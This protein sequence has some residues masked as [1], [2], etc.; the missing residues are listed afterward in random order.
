M[1]NKDDE[2]V[3]RTGTNQYRMM[4]EHRNF[5]MIFNSRDDN[6]ITWVFMVN[7]VEEATDKMATWQPRKFTSVKDI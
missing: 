4:D 2:H 5:R 1:W 6:S 7:H 3:T